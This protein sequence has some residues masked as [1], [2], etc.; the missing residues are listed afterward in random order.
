MAKMAL[1][2]SYCSINAVDV[3]AYTSKIEL[4]TEVEEKDVT[5]FASLGWKEVIGGLK[6][7]SLALTF[8]QDVAARRSTP[9]CGRSSGP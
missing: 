2:A 7:G 4:T 3:S 5:T 1:L 8:K 6:S 9:K